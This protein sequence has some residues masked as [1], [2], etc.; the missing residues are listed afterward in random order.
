MYECLLNSF[1]LYPATP[2]RINYPVF[3][4]LVKDK[5]EQRLVFLHCR[6]LL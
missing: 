5:D 6:V 3:L 4:F 1:S 2:P